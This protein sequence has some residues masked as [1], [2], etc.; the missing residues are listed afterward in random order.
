[1][2]DKTKT[3]GEKLAKNMEILKEANLGRFERPSIDALVH[4]R[5]DIVAFLAVLKADIF[6]KIEANE[7]PNLK[8]SELR[9]EAWLKEAGEGKA[10]FQKLYDEFMEEMT[11]EHQ[12]DVSFSEAHDGGGMKSWIQVKV[13]PNAPG[14]SL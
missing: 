11:N 3:Y 13:T 4:E 5:N 2:T 7:I 14:F 8:V 6:A 9:R 1:M 10:H 12:L